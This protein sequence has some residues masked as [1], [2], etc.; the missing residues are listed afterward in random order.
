MNLGVTLKA[1]EKV[2]GPALPG[3]GTPQTTL[4]AVRY[5]EGKVKKFAGVLGIRDEAKFYVHFPLT[6]DWNLLKSKKGVPDF[7]N[8]LRESGPQGAQGREALV[9]KFVE[10]V[11]EK[12]ELR[13]TLP[14]LVGNH[15]AALIIGSHSFSLSVKIT[16]DKKG[17]FKLGATF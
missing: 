7:V 3:L 5:A 8:D 9:E 11:K 13:Q 15:E 6:V 16:V 2:F 4:S 1:A 12:E 17:V 10:R 14:R